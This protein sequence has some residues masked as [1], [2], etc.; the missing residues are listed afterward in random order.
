MEDN[1]DKTLMRVVDVRQF[2]E[3]MKLIEKYLDLARKVTRKVSFQKDF[4]MKDMN[5]C[6]YLIDCIRGY[7][8]IIQKNDLESARNYLRT[9]IANG[10]T[11]QMPDNISEQLKEILDNDK[12]WNEETDKTK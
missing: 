4:Y 5:E 2:N 3:D 12:Y 7:A 11:A 8:N 10:C 1:K 6:N 9:G